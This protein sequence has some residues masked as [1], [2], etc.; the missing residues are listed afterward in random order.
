VTPDYEPDLREVSVVE[1]IEKANWTYES[2]RR[3]KLTV[4]PGPLSD[5]LHEYLSSIGEPLE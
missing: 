3:L 1:L 4:E 2:D 5:E